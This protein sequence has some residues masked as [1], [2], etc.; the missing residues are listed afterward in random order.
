ML[1]PLLGVTQLVKQ[2]VPASRMPS[3]SYVFERRA[4]RVDVPAMSAWPR[5]SACFVYPAAHYL[6]VACQKRLNILWETWS[7]TS[8][9]CHKC[10][11]KGKIGS[12]RKTWLT[13]ITRKCFSSV[14]PVEFPQAFISTSKPTGNKL[15]QPTHKDTKGSREN[16]C[17]WFVL[18][19]WPSDLFSRYMTK[20]G[21]YST[22]LMVGNLVSR[23]GWGISDVQ[24]T[25]EN[26]I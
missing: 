8:L 20:M 15:L 17:W 22:L 21:H 25:A 18:T 19:T 4:S 1:Q 23:A 11:N 5:L 10:I 9:R 24:G 2:M 13:C 26:R 14:I 7:L 6:R 3:S 12:I 16:D